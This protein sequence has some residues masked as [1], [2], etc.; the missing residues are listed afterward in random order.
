[1]RYTKKIE[2]KYDTLLKICLE[3]GISKDIVEEIIPLSLLKHPEEYVDRLLNIVVDATEDEL[4][5]EI[6]KILEEDEQEDLE[7]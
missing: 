2:K 5:D 4:E 7:Q 1:M 6:Q 3:K